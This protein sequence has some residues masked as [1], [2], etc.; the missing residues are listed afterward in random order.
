MPF[1][2][3]VTVVAVSKCVSLFGFSKKYVGQDRIRPCF[4]FTAFKG[5]CVQEQLQQHAW[6]HFTLKSFSHYNVSSMR[7]SAVSVC[8]LEVWHFHL[9]T[10][11]EC[12]DAGEPEFH[13]NSRC[14][15]AGTST[16]KADAS[17]KG[18]LGW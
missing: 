4:V 7:G 1:Q 18:L 8:I 3:D 6:Q 11:P 10:T 5:V 13:C 15:S 12:F 16:V 14:S 2:P 9:H 17:M